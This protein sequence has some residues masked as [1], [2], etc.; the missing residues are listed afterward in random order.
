MIDLNL[1]KVTEARSFK[2]GV[3][4]KVEYTFFFRD[5]SWG[6]LDGESLYIE[7]VTK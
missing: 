3:L 5:D 6:L 7:R 4:V 2:Q 1:R